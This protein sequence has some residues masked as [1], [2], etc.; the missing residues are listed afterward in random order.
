MGCRQCGACVERGERE[1]DWRAAPGTFE[2]LSSRI[3]FRFPPE[4]SFKTVCRFRR[5]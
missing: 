3:S 2:E 4:R 1:E 5:E